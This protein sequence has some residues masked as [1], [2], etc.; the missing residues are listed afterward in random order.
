HQ[1]MPLPHV[2]GLQV[3]EAHAN[4]VTRSRDP[5][6]VPAYLR[7]QPVG[8]GP[9]RQHPFHGWASP[10]P[11]WE[12]GVGPRR[13]REALRAPGSGY[14]GGQGAP[15]GPSATAPLTSPEPGLE[16]MAGVTGQPP[17]G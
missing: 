11:G 13:P 7:V 5:E 10:V 8:L 4:R 14:H 12:R 15:P 9:G 6:F 1:E 16:L 2:S 3:L 17:T